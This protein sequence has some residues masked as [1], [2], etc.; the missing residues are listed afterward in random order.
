V[1]NSGDVTD[2]DRT[3]FEEIMAGL[4]TGASPSDLTNLAVF[5]ING[6]GEIDELDLQAYREALDHAG[7]VDTNNDGQSGLADIN[8]DGTVNNC[9]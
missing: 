4:A 3:R 5:D 9:A 2:D 7:A 1:N 8:A 6:D